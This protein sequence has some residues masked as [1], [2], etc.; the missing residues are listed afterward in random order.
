MPAKA[1]VDTEAPDRPDVST[2]LRLQ[3]LGPLRIWRDSVEVAAGPAQQAVL[4]A[5]LLARAGRP[6]STDELSR[7]MWGDEPP[8]SAL[9]TIQ[10]YVG[11]LRRLFE[12][13]LRPRETG[14]FLQRRG[15]AYVCTA[16]R[17]ALDLLEFRSLVEAARAAQVEMQ[18]EQALDDYLRALALWVEPVGV[19]L[20]RGSNS[21]SVFVALN[22]EYLDACAVAAD[23]ALSLGV[24]ERALPCLHAAVAMDPYHE[25]LHAR[26]ISAL[27]AVG[28]QAEALSVFRVVR[29]RLADELGLSP[30]DALVAAERAVLISPSG[31]RARSAQPA[32]GPSV[33]LRD[34]GLVG[35]SDEFS[36]LWTAASSA[37]GGVSSLAMVEGEPGIGK[38][39]LLEAVGTRA[40][41]HG[42]FVVRGQCTESEG[43][44]ALWPWVRAITAL[45]DDLPR[46]ERESWL[47]GELRELVD[48]ADG[49]LVTTAVPDVGA[50]F[51]L[52][53]KIVALFQISA[54]RRP[55]LLVVD[56][57]QWADVA[58]LL[59]FEHLAARM[60]PGVTM[61]GA[62]RDRATATRPA[63]AT[64][65]ASV[66]RLPTHRRVRL[67]ALSVDEVGQLVQ[68]ETGAAI[69]PSVALNLHDRTAGNPFFVLELARFPGADGHLSQH[70]AP[71]GLPSSVLDVVRAR[72]SSLDEQTKYM[73]Q[74]AA[75]IGTELDIG[76]LALSSGL[77]E[78]TCLDRFQELEDLGMLT[79]NPANP[80]AVRFAH[81]I[82]RESIVAITQRA[83][84]PRMHLDVAEALD[85]ADAR[86]DPAVERIAFHLWSAG[87]LAD[88]ARTAD[89][90]LRAG[91]TAVAK[92]AYE[93][94]ERRLLAAAQ[95]ARG[96]GLGQI[97][98]IA[99]EH[100]NR[101][102][103]RSRGWGH[104]DA[105]DR[106]DG[107][108][109]DLGRD[110]EA[111]D[112]LFTRYEKHAQANQLDD[113]GR[114]ARTLLDRGE[115]SADPVVCAFG[116]LAW[117]SYECD[118]VG[119]VGQ[120]H[121]YLTRADGM[122]LDEEPDSSWWSLVRDMRGYCR[123]WLA[124]TSAL[125]GDVD[126]ARSTLL[127]YETAERDNP[128]SLVMS[129]IFSI[130]IAVLAGDVEWAASAAERGLSV[131]ADGSYGPVGDRYRLGRCWARALAG[132]SPVEMAAE[133]EVIIA[134]LADPPIVAM[135]SKYCLL[136]EMWLAAGE[137]DEAERV[138]NRVDGSLVTD[139]Q[140]YIEGLLMLLRAKLMRARGDDV[141]TVR[142]TA[143]RARAVATES[144]ALLFTR[145]AE[146]FLAS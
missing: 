118:V 33:D 20:T 18:D 121:Q 143:E 50:R 13:G 11:A 132:D 30:G 16:G 83:R 70:P 73:L 36:T 45:L 28:Q 90:L 139:G 141:A 29:R 19:G 134:S 133:A 101:A 93:T 108:A 58:S 64:M 47:T 66:S 2:S 8:P 54:A 42:M 116:L 4:L 131:D 85:Q 7:A 27:G 88:A 41:R 91:R 46:A 81:D 142:A 52:F 3:I 55:I 40:E 146:E 22:A 130:N 124:F 127:D 17:D 120:A 34:D 105:L 35:R 79:A 126:A 62:L 59:M 61:V 140:R 56:D 89:A 32:L 122:L 138:L 38:S 51:R 74:V 123:L 44:P 84:L 144:G 48:P 104:D 12:P 26:L 78:Q 60:P 75:V 76:I 25:P 97:E 128:W 129:A 125:Q 23:L 117:G 9:N 65:L 21:T 82:V 37:L 113:A 15:D 145:H 100:L 95:V 137:L 67:T 94:A 71:A 86:D 109:R 31:P 39:R 1:Q 53:E 5:V 43:T 49:E 110:R 135:P 87:P 72:T 14:A 107:L 103:I 77:D 69:A 92:C 112:L 57:V 96:A 68:I 119:H 80:R 102:A 98:L 114:V 136:A 99:L 63:L 111:A 106:A 10:K 6:V 24:P 115:A